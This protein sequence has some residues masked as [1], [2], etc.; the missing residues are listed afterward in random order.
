MDFVAGVDGGNT[1]TIALVATLDGTVMGYGR[2]GIGDIYSLPRGIHTIPAVEQ[3]M[4][5]ALSQAAIT[6]R[7]LLAGAFSMAG[8]DWPEDVEQLRAMMERQG[9]GRKILVVN[10]ALG[11]LRAGSPDGTGVVVVCGTGAATG[12]RNADGHVWHTSFWQGVHGAIQLGEKALAAVYRNELG[13]GEPT[14][15]RARALRFWD[16]ADVESVLHRL[17][18]LNARDTANVRHFAHVLLDEAASGDAVARRIVHEHG[19][20]LG[21]YALVAAR[22]VGLDATPFTL[23]LAGGVLRHSSPLL[24]DAIVERVRAAAPNVVAVNSTFEPAI[25]AVL[26]ALESAGVAIDAS[27]LARL[28]ASLPPAATWDSLSNIEFVSST[29]EFATSSFDPRR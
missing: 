4:D 6:A 22:K 3:A 15:L 25:G 27:L 9:F 16:C 28:S 23:V 1:K 20:G 12:A 2:G 5:A 26:L 21:D 17:T 8:A 29:S 13:L 7:Q 10:D 11:A 24:A 18:A 14:R 19:A